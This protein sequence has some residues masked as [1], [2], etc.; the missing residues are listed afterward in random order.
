MGQPTYGKGS[1]Q[2]LFEEPDGSGLRLTIGAYLTPA[3]YDISL[4]GGLQPDVVCA[5]HPRSPGAPPDTCMVAAL[6]ILEQ[7]Q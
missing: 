7:R 1:I 5:D 3:G 4:Q 6:Q 2:D